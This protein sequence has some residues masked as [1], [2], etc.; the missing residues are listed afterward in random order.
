[1]SGDGT[2]LLIVGVVVVMTVD[3]VIV[4]DSFAILRIVGVDAI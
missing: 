4:E 2:E 1:V 3:G